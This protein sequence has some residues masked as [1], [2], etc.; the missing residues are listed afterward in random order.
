M[1][2]NLG[3]LILFTV[4][5]SSGLNIIFQEKAN[6]WLDICNQGSTR[7]EKLA[8]GYS[9]DGDWKSDGWWSM[10][11][12][13][14]RRVYEHD[15]KNSG[16]AFYYYIEGTGWSTRADGAFCVATNRNFTYFKRDIDSRCGQTITKREC[17]FGINGEGCTPRTLT[18]FTQFVNFARFG[19]SGR[20]FTLNLR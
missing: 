17:K 6:A 16:K 12:G 15:L 20:N 4:I 11:P 1:K 3:Y 19:T 18:F 10:N 7:I 8:V 9:E 5:A 13:E 14:C 2:C